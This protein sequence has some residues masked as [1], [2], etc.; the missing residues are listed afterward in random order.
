M[1]RLVTIERI[2]PQD[3]P[4]L[5]SSLSLRSVMIEGGSAILSSF[6]HASPRPD[7]TPLV[8]AAIVTVA[9]SFIGDGIGVVPD[10]GF[11][12]A[13]GGYYR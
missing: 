2:P 9:P 1:L 3:L 10:V 4:S 7:E 13:K 5:L 8:D 6:L 12:I 11:N